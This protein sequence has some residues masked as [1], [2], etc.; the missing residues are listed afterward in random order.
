M[1]EFLTPD[2]VGAQLRVDGGTIRAWART[3][4]LPHTRIGKCIR[5]RPDEL[6]Q[7]IAQQQ[8]PRPR[9]PRSP[10]PEQQPA[11]DHQAELE[12][13]ADPVLSRVLA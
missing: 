7:W 1:S 9:A 13:H 8:G 3:R 4:G 10:N 5:I 11:D 12:L 6:E 2:E